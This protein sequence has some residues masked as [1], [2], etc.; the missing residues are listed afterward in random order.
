MSV[1]DTHASSF[2]C[3]PVLS[4]SQQSLLAD[5]SRSEAS[6][7][8]I[9]E[10]TQCLG[11]QSCGSLEWRGSRRSRSRDPIRKSEKSLFF[12][13]GRKL[14]ATGCRLLAAAQLLKERL[15]VASGLTSSGSFDSPQAWMVVAHHCCHLRC[16]SHL[17][18]F[19]LEKTF[20]APCK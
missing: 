4:T 9:D 2:L 3:S 1:E 18:G 19:V 16:S 6:S 10:E 17:L 13:A 5:F 11:E 15:L 14:L 12:C 8:P 7:L 20:A